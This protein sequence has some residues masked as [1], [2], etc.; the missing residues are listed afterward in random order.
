MDATKEL[1]QVVT[2]GEIARQ[3]ALNPMTA[4]RRAAKRGVSIDGMLHDSSGNPTPI[5]LKSRI[6]ELVKQLQ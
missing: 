6:S 5:F 2:L 3:A 1:F 4:R